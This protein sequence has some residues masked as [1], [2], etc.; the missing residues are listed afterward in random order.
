VLR[1]FQVTPAGLGALRESRRAFEALSRGLDDVLS[2][3]R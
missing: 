3:A 2:E 1:R